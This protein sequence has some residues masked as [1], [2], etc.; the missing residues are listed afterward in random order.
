[1]VSKSAVENMYTVLKGSSL[2]SPLTSSVA[3]LKREH[4]EPRLMGVAIVIDP[5]Q[6]VYILDI[7]FMLSLFGKSLEEKK[8]MNAGKPSKPKGL[9]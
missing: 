2:R 6:M 1:M 4:D 7:T 8:P 9:S 3:N 5:F